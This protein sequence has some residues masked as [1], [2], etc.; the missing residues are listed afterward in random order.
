MPRPVQ[1]RIVEAHEQL[2]GTLELWIE[3]LPQH[4]TIQVGVP[5]LAFTN[6]K[7][8]YGHAYKELTWEETP[9][10]PG[11]QPTVRPVS[12]RIVDL[13]P[14]ADDRVLA[15]IIAEHLD[16]FEET[17]EPW[18][19]QT[20]PPLEIFRGNPRFR[21]VTNHHN[22]PRPVPAR[23]PERRSPEIR[24]VGSPILP[25]VV[26]DPDKPRSAEGGVT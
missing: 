17:G 4:K 12:E 9:S 7:L 10:G 26:R 21:P 16:R 6:R 19:Q 8:L 24:N 13:Y 20:P 3:L 2:D 5:T 25:P 23:A 14:D 22:N 11:Q 15:D 18:E 1:W